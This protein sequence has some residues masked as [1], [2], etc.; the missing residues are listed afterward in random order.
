MWSALWC[1]HKENKVS[2]YDV[3]RLYVSTALQ[4]KYT[5]L[6]RK[7][8]REYNPVLTIAVIRVIYLL[9]SIYLL[10]CMLSCRTVHL[11]AFLDSTEYIFVKP[12]IGKINKNC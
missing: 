10:V 6:K 2:S 1:E 7:K 9:V 11:V 8:L 12:K 3:D 4:H 5:P